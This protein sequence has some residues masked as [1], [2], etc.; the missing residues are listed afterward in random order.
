[1]QK[2]KKILVY[3][4]VIVIVL[5]EF[6]QSGLTN[7]AKES[8]AAEALETRKDDAVKNE[9]TGREDD[10]ADTEE[11]GKE[12]DSADIEEAEKEDA[13]DNSEE[14]EKEDVSPDTGEV[15]KE[16]AS[17][18]SEEVEKEDA[19]PDT[20][21]VEENVSADSEEV[22]K[23]DTS[24]YTEEAKDGESTTNTEVIE[25][26]KEVT[27]D[28]VNT[29]I[30]YQCF[31][32]GE[33]AGNTEGYTSVDEMNSSGTEYDGYVKIET[34]KT[35]VTVTPYAAEGYEFMILNLTGTDGTVSTP[36]TKDY[37]KKVDANGTTITSETI[38]AGSEPGYSFTVDSQK[39]TGTGAA[40]GTVYSKM[41]AISA[42]FDPVEGLLNEQLI[43]GNM[44]VDDSKQQTKGDI[45]SW[46]GPVENNNLYGTLHVGIGNNKT[47][48]WN[49][50]DCGNGDYITYYAGE[51]S[52]FVL[53]SVCAYSR[54]GWSDTRF[55]AEI[56]GSYDNTT[57]QRIAYINGQDVA[58]VNNKK[59]S[60]IRATAEITAEYPYIRLYARQ[61][62][63]N[64]S[65]LKLYGKIKTTQVTKEYLFF[66]DGKK[67]ATQTELDL[68]NVGASYDGYAET[69][70]TDGE[71]VK[72][73]MHAAEGYEFMMLNLTDENGNISTPLTKD[74]RKTMSGG[75]AGSGS[76]KNQ[77]E[78][79][80]SFAIDADQDSETDSKKIGTRYRSM[81]TI[82]VYF[83]SSQGILNEKLLT[84]G[85]EKEQQ[86]DS[87]KKPVRKWLGS[88]T[89]DADSALYGTLHV[90]TASGKADFWNGADSA[91]GD[92]VTYYAGDN[93]AFEITQVCAYSRLGWPDRF[94][95]EVLGSYDNANYEQIAVTTKGTSNALDKYSIRRQTIQTSEKY[96]YI[97]LRSRSK[98][99]DISLIKLYGDI[100]KAQE[101]T[102]V[103]KYIFYKEGNV[104]VEQDS[105]TSLPSE[106]YEGYV[107]VSTIAEKSVTVTVTAKTGYDFMMLNLTDEEG[108]VTTPL[109]KDWIRDGKGGCAKNE[110]GKNTCGF[111]IGAD[112]T[113][114]G[115]DDIGSQY[116][117]MPVITAF[118]SKSDQNLLNNTLLEMTPYDKK[119]SDEAKPVTS[120]MAQAATLNVNKANGSWT[121][122]DVKGGDYV[123]YSAGKGKAFHLEELDIYSRWGFSDNR[124]GAVLE[125][126]NDGA[127]FV[128]ILT[129]KN[130]PAE[131]KYSVKR[132][133][134]A[135]PETEKLKVRMLRLRAVS[136]P[137]DVCLLNIYGTV[138]DTDSSEL[139]ELKAEDDLVDYPEIK[140]PVTWLDPESEAVFFHPGVGVTKDEL[141]NVRNQVENK[142]DPWYSYY[143]KMLS[144]KY[145]SREFTC[146]NAVNGEI[147]SDAWSV[148]TMELTVGEDAQRAYTQTLLY[149]IT[150]DETY[151]SNAMKIIRIYEQMDPAKYSYYVDAHIHAPTPVYK[152]IQ[153]AEL[154]RYTACTDRDLNW[155][156]EDTE[157]FT[158]NFIDP[159]CS[160]FLDYND[161]FMNQHNFP[162]LG[163][164]SAAIFKDDM[165]EYKEK[166]EWMTF[167][168]TAP[169][170]YFTGSI[171]WLFRWTD[172]TE[173]TG[174]HVQL[175]EMGRDLAH[176][177]DDVNTMSILTRMLWLQG[178]K[179]DPESGTVSDAD[180]AVNIYEYLDHAVMRG[181]DY[182][183]KYDMGYDIDW[184]PVQTDKNGSRYTRS[185]DE[186][187]GRLY[188]IGLADLYYM[189]RYQLGY[190]HG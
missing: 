119:I 96:P 176:A 112:E 90:G 37:R 157:K 140:D 167:N 181:A 84:E 85:E 75:T 19:S 62:N 106:E 42:A 97:R 79:T 151:R 100:V 108:N 78:I 47:D 152:M 160:T 14:V 159:A 141:I 67:V 95:A 10:A 50:K 60:I 150:G 101:M 125:A 121:G 161:K 33:T 190:T 171:K 145:A 144:T 105:L 131:E 149:V 71:A 107:K 186:Y 64:V 32:N 178:T 174:K 98:N 127:N 109:T 94:D 36:L 45:R 88:V 77:Q 86:Q 69:E 142:K 175:V 104:V 8:D 143:T 116:K 158:K 35:T 166:V 51:G 27:S 93:K 117:E 156:K 28:A 29:Q 113:L 13:I 153:A 49:G 163:T 38:A 39:T 55:V 124:F 54:L 184:N 136:N 91:E 185:S 165:Q 137:A 30:R 22:E 5:S 57:Y 1:M 61:T 148:Q 173:G 80:Y 133:N 154:L 130:T 102:P 24:A 179:V 183:C 123:T 81:P 115:I 170:P 44:F 3:F 72:I 16:D 99:A 76:M 74:Y 126:S 169:D 2:V 41:P 15:E 147:K 135:M 6:S 122:V 103:E 21:E 63:A 26:V 172:D 164:I 180:S 7:S 146:N 48:A 31:K 17:D 52:S 9:E 70:V 4:L 111:I 11:A 23:E 56:Q 58:D 18:N 25:E 65:L 134:R 139:S 43:N 83:D 34:D 129:A 59:N 82:A 187:R 182:F 87:T 120:W 162:L 66:K 168:E 53:D 138:K 73:T 177:G 89:N 40:L 110:N 189:Y 188:L 20:G 114:T 132:I 155:T 12:E 92:Y 118:F 68:N 128:P 46:L